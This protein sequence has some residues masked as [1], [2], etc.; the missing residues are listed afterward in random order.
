MAKNYF[1]VVLTTKEHDKYRLVVYRY[2]DPGILN[3]CPMCQLLRAIHKFQ[4]EYAEIHREHCSR[5]PPRKWYELGRVMPSIVLRKYGLEKH[6]EMSFEPSRVPP[7]SAL[8]LIPG[9]TASNWKQ[10]IW[11]VD[12]DVTML[13]KRP[14]HIRARLIQLELYDRYQQSKRCFAFRTIH[15]SLEGGLPISG[16][17]P[18]CVL[19]KKGV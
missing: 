14:L 19:T 6:Y 12:G 9:A 16:G 17:P 4:Q 10:H 7:A 13:G 15:I 18:F 5:I 3:T 2:K 8:K 11:Y 1:G